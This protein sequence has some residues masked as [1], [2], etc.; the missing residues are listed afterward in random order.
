MFFSLQNAGTNSAWKVLLFQLYRIEN[1][2]SNRLKYGQVFWPLKK[3]TNKNYIKSLVYK[4]IQWLLFFIVSWSWSG[5]GTKIQWKE[6]K[7]VLVLFYHK[8]LL[9]SAAAA[10]KW[11]NWNSKIRFSDSQF[12]NLSKHKTYIEKKK[13]KVTQSCLTLCDPMDYTVHGILQAR[14]LE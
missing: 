9:V 3:Q 7:K 6:R 8:L 14:I 4:M 12:P 11:P 13:V 5:L 10:A 2:S 1:W